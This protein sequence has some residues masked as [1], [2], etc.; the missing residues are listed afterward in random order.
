MS[1]HALSPFDGHN[2]GIQ[3]GN[4]ASR[5]HAHPL[6][7]GVCHIIHHVVVEDA[8]NVVALDVP[9]RPLPFRRTQHWNTARQRR[10]SLARPPPWLWCVSYYTPCCCRRC[11]QCRSTR[12]PCTPSP[13]STDTTLEYSKATAH[14]AGTPTP[15]AVV[16]VILYTMLL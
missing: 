12:C 15:L 16:C 8:Y 11:V 7:C 13:L 14:L 9:A 1:L 5:W 6:G 2:I 10:I 3:Q 4:G